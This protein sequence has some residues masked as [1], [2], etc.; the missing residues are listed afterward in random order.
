MPSYEYKAV[1]PSGEVVTEV[2]EAANE[3]NVSKEIYH[4]GYRPVSIK[5]RKEEKSIASGGVFAKKIK[6]DE[7]ILFTRELVTLLRAGVPMLTALEAL[8]SQSTKEMGEVLNQVYVDV[9]SGK[10]FSQS[11]DKHPKVFTKIGIK[12]ILYGKNI[13][14]KDIERAI[15]LSQTKYCSASAMLRHSAQI[16]TCYEI[17]EK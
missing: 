7:I 2:L 9:M 11:L 4:K 5:V 16:E 3:Q 14:R 6:T 8:S 13:N 15:E 10:S 1:T 12:F 17:K